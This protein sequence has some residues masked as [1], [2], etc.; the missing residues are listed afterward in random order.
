M[1]V[2]LTSL[3]PLVTV[4]VGVTFLAES[5]TLRHLV[6]IILAAVAVLLLAE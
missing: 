5:M 2:P 4:V 1:V 6:G 3:Y